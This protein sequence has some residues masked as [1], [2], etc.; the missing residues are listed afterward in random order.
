MKYLEDIVVGSV[1]N[2]GHYQV[3]EAEIISFAMRYDNQPFH[4][5]AEAAMDSIYGGLIASGWHVCAIFMRMACDA[6]A[7]ECQPHGMGAPGLDDLKWLQPVRPSDVLSARTE[8]LSADP[9]RLKSCLGV[10][11]SKVQISNQSGKAVMEMTAI[12]W[13]LR[14]PVPTTD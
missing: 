14:Q 6:G 7:N 12:N 9:S 2:F 10:V 1:E 4:T 13:V 8:I 5:D 3:S 11:R